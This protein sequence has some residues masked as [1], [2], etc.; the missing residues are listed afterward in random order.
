MSQQ[1]HFHRRAQSPNPQATI[2][3]RRRQPRSQ[4]PPQQDSTPDYTSNYRID[5]F[6][7]NSDSYTPQF[8]SHALRHANYD[9]P[10][11]YIPRP[12]YSHPTST[13]PSEAPT[14]C[15]NPFG[16][17]SSIAPSIG[18][19]SYPDDAA[20][21]VSNFMGMFSNP[22]IPR[23]T[24]SPEYLKGKAKAKRNRSPTP[25]TSSRLSR[26]TPDDPN[27]EYFVYPEYSPPSKK[28]PSNGQNTPMG[29]SSMDH[30]SDRDLEK[31]YATTLFQHDPITY[32]G[33]RDVAE[34]APT[35]VTEKEEN[36]L[37]QMAR[38]PFPETLKDMKARAR[39]N[40][41]ASSSQV[42]APPSSEGHKKKQ[43]KTEGGDGSNI[44]CRTRPK[45]RHNW[46][47]NFATRYPG[48]PI[49]PAAPTFR[50]TVIALLHAGKA[51]YDLD[52]QDF[53]GRI[54]TMIKR[55]ED[56]VFRQLLVEKLETIRDP[57]AHCERDKAPAPGPQPSQAGRSSGVQ[58]SADAS[59]VGGR[60]QRGHN[61]AQLYGPDLPSSYT[62]PPAHDPT[63]ST[64][65]LGPDFA[66]YEP[67]LS[68]GGPSDDQPGYYD[69][70]N[71]SY[72]GFYMGGGPYVDVAHQTSHA[73]GASPKFDGISMPFE[74]TSFSNL[75]E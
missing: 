49:P 34:K 14:T 51:Q 1:S 17:P 56:P 3:D 4:I 60:P 72:A 30:C 21:D 69:N 35:K 54:I 68:F 71:P 11:G 52:P 18:V 61:Q 22:P 70:D 7:A 20:T 62:R 45:G 47:D 16:N 53:S 58:W 57:D 28:H 15:T 31:R 42:K 59:Q 27:Y 41:E 75:Q 46:E 43:V 40:P 50:P 13:E 25:P 33:L 44:E 73:G 65:I 66:S 23:L 36:Y 2:R 5:E 67:N 26:L 55:C 32:F 74:N 6:I 24:V 38:S 9:G 48:H 37:K 12:S 64:S 19:H 63:P 8:G 10:P 39:N 29:Q